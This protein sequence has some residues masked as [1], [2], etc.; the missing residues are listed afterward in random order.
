MSRDAII[1]A[2]NDYD[3][4]RILPLSYAQ[5]DAV[6]VG[7]VLR[8]RCGFNVRSIIGKTASRNNVLRAMQSLNGGET[9]VVYFAL[10][11]QMRHGCYLLHT[12]DSD[13]EGKNALTFGEVVRQCAV[14]CGYKEV[15][16]I[17]DACRSMNSDTSTSPAPALDQISAK[18]V[19][20]NVRD[21]AAQIKTHVHNVT[22]QTLETAI[23]PE[24][25]AWIEVLYGCSDGQYCYEDETLKHGLFS[26]GLVSAL[27]GTNGE[28]V[29]LRGCGDRAARVIK[30]WSKKD[31]DR[32]CQQ[33]MHYSQTGR[34]GIVIYND[35]ISTTGE[36]FSGEDGLRDHVNDST[37]RVSEY[38][39]KIDNGR[40]VLLHSIGQGGMGSVWLARDGRLNRLVALKCPSENVIKSK[41]SSYRFMQEARA[42]AQL[43]HS[44]IVNIYNVHEIKMEDDNTLPL[45]E[46]EYIEGSTL[47]EAVER[48]GKGLETNEVVDLA[49]K[50]CEALEEA[51]NCDIIHRD[52]KPANII[53]SVEGV[54]KIVD[55]GIA[56]AAQGLGVTR[57]TRYT[58]TGQGEWGL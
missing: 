34:D 40:L 47:Q 48:R 25:V 4:K 41:H 29:D 54:P 13:F 44:S 43:K 18:T 11:G 56:L 9:L 28:D 8:T 20:D 17:L 58:M 6:A 15:A 45:I 35:K 7:E 21:I 46:M 23:S 52:I 55:F 27:A 31:A 2:V 10:H 30:R 26:Y 5:A 14:H 36:H 32:P 1:I 33:P 19:A 3:D 49:D 38:L 22:R 51:H 12:Y 37:A 53:L 24:D 57:Y 39:A 16:F 42:A 50:L